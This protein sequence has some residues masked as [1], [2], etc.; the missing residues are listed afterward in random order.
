M[1]TAEFAIIGADDM[2]VRAFV[3]ILTNRTVVRR[4]AAFFAVLAIRFTNHQNL[5]ISIVFVVAVFAIV[6]VL[7]CSVVDAD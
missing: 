4:D 1:F 3:A 7:A 6:T 5:G 2:A